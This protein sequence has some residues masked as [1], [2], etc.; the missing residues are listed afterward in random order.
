MGNMHNGFLFASAKE[1]KEEAELESTSY[2]PLS[3][4]GFALFPKNQHTLLSIPFN[5]TP[6]WAQKKQ[7]HSG[8]FV[9]LLVVVS[10]TYDRRNTEEITA[11][12][13]STNF[14]YTKSPVQVLHRLAPRQLK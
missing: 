10:K 3:V 9:S 14:V 7:M 1:Y 11:V 4:I 13:Y 5:P 2:T 12:W 8:V 6:S